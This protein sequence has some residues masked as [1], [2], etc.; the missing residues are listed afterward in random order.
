M[1]TTKQLEQK[2]RALE[3]MLASYGIEAEATSVKKVEDRADFIPHGSDGHVAFLG[4]VPAEPGDEDHI[5]F[6]SPRTGKTYRLEDEIMQ[7]MNF[8]DPA[9]A[10]QMT[11]QQK[12]N[13]LELVPEVPEDAK[14]MWRPAAV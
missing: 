9:K 7:F 11:L 1:A 5:T 2:L 14:P 3:A 4:L 12:V 6:T 8:H 13:E 10:A